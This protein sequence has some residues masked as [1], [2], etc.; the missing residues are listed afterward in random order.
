MMKLC[1]TCKIPHTY[2]DFNRSSYTKDGFF[3]EC[4]T[5]S[6]A[7]TKAYRDKQKAK[8]AP[9][10]P[11][12]LTRKENEMLADLLLARPLLIGKCLDTLSPEDR[13]MIAAKIGDVIYARVGPAGYGSRSCS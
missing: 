11:L 9:L 4:R 13:R 12:P 10:K 5:C 7:R 2:T 1:S 8:E 3:S 6:K